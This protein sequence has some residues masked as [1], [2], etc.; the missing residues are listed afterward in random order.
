MSEDVKLK[1]FACAQCRK[2]YEAPTLEA[3]GWHRRH[4]GTHVCT[5]CLPAGRAG[6]L[7]RFAEEAAI[8]ADHKL[9]HT[10]PATPAEKL[11]RLEA[12]ARLRAK[13]VIR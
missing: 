4:D 1:R 3:L 9:V 13:N 8:E 5:A 6:Q 7:A 11:A 12:L 10:V 2:E